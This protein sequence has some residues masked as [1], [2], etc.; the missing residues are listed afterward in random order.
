MMLYLFARVIQALILPPGGFLLLMAFGFFIVRGFRMIGRLFIASGFILLYL[1]STQFVSNALILPLEKSHPPLPA[2]A[3]PKVDAVVVLGGGVHDL[4]WLGLAAQPSETSLVRTVAGAALVRNTR[5][6]LVLAGGI[7]GLSGGDAREGEAMAR[8]AAEFGVP[9]RSLLVE[10]NSRDTR[11]NAAAVK[12]MLKGNRIALVT[13]AYHMKRAAGL[14]RKQGFDV[15]P[16][17]CGY[18]GDERPHSF[19][20]FIPNA[21]SLSASSAALAEYI[22]LAWYSITGEL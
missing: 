8:V 11:E 17:P 16:A 9:Q 18:R 13:S 2:R 10:G 20:S 6:P 14:F 21:D 19:H 12:R 15:V 3:L 4:S 1:V 22:A 5:L 7:A